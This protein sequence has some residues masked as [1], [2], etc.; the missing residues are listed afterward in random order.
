MKNGK[1]QAAI[2]GC[3]N[4]GNSHA[5]AILA[6]Q[7]L[8]DLYAVCDLIPEKAEHYKE[9]YHA[10]RIYTDYHEMLANP[11]IDMV[12]ICTPSGYHAVHA[13]DCMNAGKNILC[14]KPLDITS[15]KLDRMVQAAKTTGVK[16]GAVFQYR[17]YAGIRKAKQ[18][19]DGGEL[20]PLHVCNAFY[21]QYRSPEYYRSAGWRGTWE[22]DGGGSTMNQG[23][24]I[25]DILSYLS[26]GIR[27]VYAYAPTLSREIE[28]EDVAVAALT[29]QCGAVGLYESTTLCNPSDEVR[30]E[31]LCEN[32][33]IVFSDPEVKLYTP[34]CPEG[35]ILGT[36]DDMRDTSGNPM[37]IS[38]QG[39]AFLIRN[40]AESILGKAE[41]FV[42][43]EKARGAV[44]TILAMY[45]SSQMKKEI[46][47]SE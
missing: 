5:K 28:V 24:H 23:I 11:E 26:G 3:G 45:R 34:D 16:A 18:I 22:I 17:T 35:M 25:L 29:F 44:D 47:L 15:D 10:S 38:S 20:G 41:I 21:K 6:N 32:G 1:L 14:E 2:L 42:P 43:F 40:L 4:I 8:V 7:D 27:S 12:S 19:L 37:A 33:R 13:I 46:V 9:L 39:H 36:E 31:F 30:A